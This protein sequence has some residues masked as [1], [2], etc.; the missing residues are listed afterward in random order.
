MFLK[1]RDLDINCLQ[2]DMENQKKESDS[3]DLIIR[4]LKIF[5]DSLSKELSDYRQ[6]SNR[7]FQNINN[8]INEKL[9]YQKEQYEAIL[10]GI[11]KAFNQKIENLSEGKP[12][13]ADLLKKIAYLEGIKESSENRK[14][15]QEVTE[16]LSK[17]N[18]LMLQ[19]EREERNTESI[20]DQV[21]ILKWVL[22][23]S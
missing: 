5:T 22:G 21:D 3:K 18:D 4:G 11:S 10:I 14:T 15:T 20:K 13:V 12:V 2:K 7:R 19:M 17:L 23:K 8:L 16:R 9:D 6:D 1:N